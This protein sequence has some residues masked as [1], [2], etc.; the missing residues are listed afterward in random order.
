MKITGSSTERPDLMKKAYIITPK[1]GDYINRYD[2]KEEGGL[3]EIP[4]EISIPG[5][6]IYKVNG[7]QAKEQLRT[8]PAGAEDRMSVRREEPEDDEKRRRRTAYVKLKRGENL[9][10]MTNEDGR[11]VQQIKI[12][13]NDAFVGKY[14]FSVD[15]NIWFLKDIS[16]N[17]DRYKSVFDNPYLALYKELHDLYGTKVHF[18]IYYMTEGFTL[19]EMTGKFRDEWEENSD[20]IAMT[21]HACSDKPDM[22]YKNISYEEMKEHYEIVTEQIR[23]FAGES[24][25]SPFT[26]IHW[27]EV[28]KEGCLALRDA[29]IKGLAGYFCFDGSG[30]PVVSYYLDKEQI[31]HLNS[32][33]IWKDN[34]AGLIF[35]KNDIVINMHS[36]NEI[37]PLLDKVKKDPHRSGFIEMMIH[38]QYY[39]RDYCNYQPDYREKVAA[40][41]EWAAGNGYKP[42]LLKEVL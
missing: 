11:L 5:E 31:A 7:V 2:G 29:G 21:F 9:L 24:L 17:K 19:K 20:W 30:R 28:T 14:R 10:T 37:K 41:V 18:N 25:L 13:R 3:L 1:E 8:E 32:R 40:A 6:G 42:A 33:D 12:Y 4:V 38:E 36:L 34:G 22:I 27:G 23:N 35:I 26:T 39:Y 15:D 16:Q